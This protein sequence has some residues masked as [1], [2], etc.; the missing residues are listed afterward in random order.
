MKETTVATENRKEWKNGFN[1]K[2]V[3]ERLII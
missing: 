2:E 3:I 1:A